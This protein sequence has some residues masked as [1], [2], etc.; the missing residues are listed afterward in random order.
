LWE[1]TDPA[2]LSHP[3][4]SD[5]EGFEEGI[6]PQAPQLHPSIASTS[7]ISAMEQCPTSE[8]PSSEPN[9]YG[10]PSHFRGDLTFLNG[11]NSKAVVH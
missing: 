5:I 3:L 8:E 6:A 9:V 4:V 7:T 1:D 2:L 10:T 11:S